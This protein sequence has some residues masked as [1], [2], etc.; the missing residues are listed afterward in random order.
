M[1]RII[2][3]GQLGSQPSSLV[4]VAF[5][6]VMPFRTGKNQAKSSTATAVKPAGY[7]RHLRGVYSK[8]EKT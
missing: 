5:C 7:Q 2:Q 1:K 4:A 3:N 8:R 6:T